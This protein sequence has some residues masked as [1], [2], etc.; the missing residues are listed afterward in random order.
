[1]WMPMLAIF[2]GGRVSQTP[3]SPSMRS[4][5]RPSFASVTISASSSSRQ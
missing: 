4:P 3:V 2:R 1:M 5:S